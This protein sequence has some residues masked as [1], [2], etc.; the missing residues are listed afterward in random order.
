MKRLLGDFNRHPGWRR[1]G[2]SPRCLDRRRS[3]RHHGEIMVRKSGVASCPCTAIACCTAASNRRLQEFVFVIGT[4]RDWTIHLAREFTTIDELS[5]HRAALPCGPKRSIT[6]T[7]NGSQQPLDVRL[8][9]NSTVGPRR[10]NVRSSPE[11]T[12]Q[13]CASSWPDAFD[14]SG[15]PSFRMRA[16]CDA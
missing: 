10:L 11:G 15:N 16:G 13:L 1:L 4:Q 7:H 12:S 8:G 9:S 3:I 14:A 6:G 2:R 5:S